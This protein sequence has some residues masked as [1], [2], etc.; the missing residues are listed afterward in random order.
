MKVD[1]VAE[2]ALSRRTFI[3]CRSSTLT[4]VSRRFNWFKVIAESIDD[5]AAAEPNTVRARVGC[6]TPVG[7][8]FRMD[9]HSVLTVTYGCRYRCRYYSLG[10]GLEKVSIPTQNLN[11]CVGDVP[12][13]LIA[14][15]NGLLISTRITEAR[16]MLCLF[17]NVLCV[18]V[19]AAQSFCSVCKR[20]GLARLVYTLVRCATCS[21]LSPNS[22][23]YRSDNEL[24][25]CNSSSVLAFSFFIVTCQW[26][27]W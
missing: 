11:E 23:A 27:Q 8:F 7:A 9:N 10:E 16:N 2:V 17:V 13:R 15:A 4:A 6:C 14:D 3:F 12:V 1:E 21:S 25:Y 19:V 26:C 22:G 18:R 20:F 5:D 24:T